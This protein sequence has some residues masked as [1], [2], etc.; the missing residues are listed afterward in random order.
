MEPSPV[1][2]WVDRM[3]KSKQ[4]PSADLGLLNDALKRLNRRTRFRK[5]L[6]STIYT[7]IVVS[8]VAVLVAVLLMPVLR[9][10]GNSM[11]PTLNEG[12]IV[13]SLKGSDIEP[14]DVVG[15][16]YGSKL[17][18][19]RCIA[20]EHQWVNIDEHGNVYVDGELLEEPYLTEKAFGE[21]NLELPYQVPDG[22]IFVMGDQRE[23]SID[24][25]NTSVGCIDTDNT[26]GRIVFRVWPFSEFGFINRIELGECEHEYA[27][28]VTEP[29]CT[30][31]GRTDYTCAKCGDSY[32]EEI[33][34]LDHDFVDGKCSRCG[35]EEPVVECPSKKYTDVPAKGEW[36]HESIDFCIDQGY[37]NGVD[38][39]LFN[40]TGNSTRAQFVTILYRVAGQPK[41][42]ESKALE[43]VDVEDD[44]WYSEAIAWASAEGI[45]N[46]VGEDK[47]NPMGAITREQIASIF[48]CYAKAEKVEGD[49]KAFPDGEDA[50]AYAVD[51]LVWA[52][53][54]GIISGVKSGDVTNLKPRDNATRVQIASILMRYLNGKY[55]CNG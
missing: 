15:V 38:D 1:F 40:P 14:G 8:A 19:K 32:E 17:L 6:R 49:L 27:K 10:Y 24:S 30:E 23:T 29:S 3:K 41:I 7:L 54:E 48:Y 46:G 16:Y 2:R 13:I 20:L 18:I 37:M 25:R 35:A 21:C 44:Q 47:F 39:D 4:A 33:A 51:A 31:K 50:A 26:V 55:E 11:T 28:V 36:A 42:D 43:F 22:C 34:A 53:K 9:I 45:V 5:L 52:V 12:E